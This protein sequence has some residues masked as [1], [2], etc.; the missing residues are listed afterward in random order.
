ML[1]SQGVGP[2]LPRARDWA[3]STVLTPLGLAHLCLSLQGQLHCVALLRYRACSTANEEQG[4]LSSSHALGAN[5]L[6]ITHGDGASRKTSLPLCLHHLMTDEWQRP[7][8][9][10]SYLQ[11][12][13]PTCPL[14][15]DQLYWAAQVGCRT[16]PPELVTLGIALLIARSGGTWEGHQL[17]ASTPL[18]QTSEGS[19]L[20]HSCHQGQ[21][22]YAQGLLS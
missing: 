16:R 13:A 8:L 3:S 18:W 7:A 20:P 1:P 15:Q 11:L 19:A 9:P 2:A 21:L 4:Q 14:R 6:T 12:R 22:H 5:S 10:S 17:C